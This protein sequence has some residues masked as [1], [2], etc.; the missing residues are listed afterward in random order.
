MRELAIERNVGIIALTESHLTEEILDA[1]IKMKN[2]EILRSDRNG[3]R[4]GG[5]VVYLRS[6]IAKKT[7]L[8]SSG[9]EENHEWLNLVIEDVNI[10][11]TVLYR[12]PR[13]EISNLRNYLE[14]LRG[15]LSRLEETG[16]TLCM[17][18][19]LNMPTMNWQIINT[20][21]TAG[22]GV[23]VR[24]LLEFMEEKCLE[25]YVRTPTR[26]ENILDV[27]LTDDPDVVVDVC[28]EDNSQS[29]HRLVFVETNIIENTSI[30]DQN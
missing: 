17:C 19:D 27:F 15:D 13:G 9:S 24:T 25:Q 2:Y 5:V 22:L 16:L 3:T 7:R 12:P 29:D 1:E 8:L 26:A 18:G 6:N 30:E 21:G 10:V 20:Q 11:F 4:K 14:T 23:H 28:V